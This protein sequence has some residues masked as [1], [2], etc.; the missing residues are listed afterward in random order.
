MSDNVAKHASASAQLLA[1]RR[2]S[3]FVNDSEAPEENWDDDLE[4]TL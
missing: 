4:S 2:Q 1:S 3:Q